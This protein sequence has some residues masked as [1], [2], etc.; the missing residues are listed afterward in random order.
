VQGLQP[1]IAFAETAKRGSFAA[2]AR[3]VGCTPSTLAKAVSRLEAQ[4]GLRLFHRTTRQ[5]ALTV[6]GERL[7]GRCQRVLAELDQLQTEAS[8]VSEEPTGTLR[9][10]MPVFFG[11]RVMLP[12][13]AQFARDHPGLGIDARLSDHYVDLVR[14]GIDIA[15]RWG[16]LRDSTLVARRITSQAL[17]LV[18][19]PDYLARAGTPATPAELESH[20]A[21]LF[22]QP[23][24]GRD[25]P[26]YLRVR[27]RDLTVTPPSRLRFGAGDAI[28]SAAAAGMGIAQ[29]P[30]Y[31]AIEGI[32]RGRLVELLPQYRPAELPISAVMPSARMVPPRVRAFLDLITS[33]PDAFPPP[34][35]V[36][37]L[38]R[39]PARARRSARSARTT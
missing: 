33:Q 32:A 38:P 19:S 36:P 2:A 22:R 39:A 17:L 30:H 6:D 25:R 31:M 26:W 12:L 11:R 18:A 24:T 20:S 9:V 34:P 4:L 23:G 13:L 21:V 37:V 3:E 35:P 14:D 7:F 15:F 10:D 1:L 29:V 28:S 16:A 8:G 27:S 5:V